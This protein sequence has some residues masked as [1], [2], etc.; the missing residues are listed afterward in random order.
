MWSLL[1]AVT[2]VQLLQNSRE[3]R[4]QH[5]RA[6]L[7]GG[8]YV[9]GRAAGKPAV[10][11]NVMKHSCGLMLNWM[12]WTN[13]LAMHP[14]VDMLLVYCPAGM[15]AQGAPEAV[16]AIVEDT[17]QCK[18]EATS[19]ASD[20]VVLFNIL[21]VRLNMEYQRSVVCVDSAHHVQT[22]VCAGA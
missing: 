2:V 5:S 12:A 18:F 16:N 11:R 9:A 13:G 6:A 15:N 17:T 8:S 19:P 7:Q 14:C 20:E 22:C 1:A 3:Q 10:Y 21:Q 4:P